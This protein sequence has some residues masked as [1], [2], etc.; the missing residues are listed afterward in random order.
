MSISVSQAKT[1]LISFLHAGRSLISDYAY[2]FSC[3]HA[4]V[5]NCLLAEVVS[6]GYGIHTMGQ[7][8]IPRGRRPLLINQSRGTWDHI[9]LVI[10]ASDWLIMYVMG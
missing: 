10:V 1:M 7:T 2:T 6:M 9:H 4:N 5:Q 8:H 3:V